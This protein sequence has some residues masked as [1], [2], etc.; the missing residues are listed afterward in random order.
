M[1]FPNSM[2]G[3][4]LYDA[5]KDKRKYIKCKESQNTQGYME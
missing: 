3:N 5:N 4:M 2:A 1:K